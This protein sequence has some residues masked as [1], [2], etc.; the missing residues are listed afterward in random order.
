MTPIRVW[1]APEDV[2]ADLGR[3]VVTIGVLVKISWPSAAGS[4]QDACGFGG[5]GFTS[6]RHMRQLPAMLRRSW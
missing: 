2:P 1:R 4:A 3:T 5:P 6:T